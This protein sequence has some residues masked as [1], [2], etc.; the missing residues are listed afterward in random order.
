[1]KTHEAESDLHKHKVRNEQNFLVLVPLIW[2]VQRLSDRAPPTQAGLAAHWAR[3]PPLLC[4]E[5]QGAAPAVAALPLQDLR[6]LG[7][8]RGAA[9]PHLPAQAPG[10]GEAPGGQTHQGGSALLQLLPGGGE[11]GEGGPHL[12]H[13]RGE[14]R[15]GETKETREEI[16]TTK[17]WF[18]VFD[19]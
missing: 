1:M 18:V 11:D 16:K 8:P 19:P 13:W 7:P 3:P 6:A 2:A 12:T 14:E 9:A 10:G 5:P 15:G 4:R 17:W